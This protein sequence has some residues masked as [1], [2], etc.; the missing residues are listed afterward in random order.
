MSYNIFSLHSFP[1]PNSAHLSL[2]Q[3]KKKKKKPTTVTKHGVQFVLA[4]NTWAQGLF[5]RVVDIPS[6]TP[7]EFF[8]SWHLSAAN[9]FLFRR[10]LCTLHLLHTL[11]LC[12]LIKSLWVYMCGCPVMPGK[13]F[14]VLHHRWIVK[15]FQIFNYITPC[16]SQASNIFLSLWLKPILLPGV[17]FSR[18]SLYFKRQAKIR[19]CENFVTAA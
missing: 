19:H 12:M 14:Q 6:V 17:C 3:I 5:W 2:S 11:I 4:N 15:S 1:S 7:V 10:T 16:R 13:H 9:S 18:L 8:L